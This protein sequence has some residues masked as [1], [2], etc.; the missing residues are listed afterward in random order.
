VGGPR[1]GCV[2]VDRPTRFIIGWAF[3]P[4]EDA[5]APALVAKTRDRTRRRKGVPWLT[6]GRR[7][8]RKVIRRVYRDPLRTGKPGRPRLVPTPGVGLTQAVKQRRK[9]RVVGVEVRRVLGAPIE[10]PYVVCEERLNGVL[11]DR[12]A[13]LTRKTHAFAKAK[14]TWDAAVA[15]CLFEINWLRP[16]QALR[17]PGEGLPGGRRYRQRIPA[18]YG[19]R[20]DG[21]YLELGGVP[22]VAVLSIF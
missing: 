7:V 13:C 18:C 5:A 15:L 2:S 12:L 22:D 10:C 20:P 21:S 4:S 14:R 17:E 16:H 9:G 3:G 1:W 11:R 6:D 8:Y 19:D